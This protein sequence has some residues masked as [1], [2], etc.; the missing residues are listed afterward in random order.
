MSA[1][2]RRCV[3]LSLAFLMLLSG[4][5]TPSVSTP[6]TVRVLGSWTGEELATFRAVIAPF[7]KKS[8]VKIEY[9]STRDLRGVLQRELASGSPPDIAGLD[10]PGHMR[11]LAGVG[12]LHDLSDT[13]EIG[14]Y[15]SAVAPT[16]IDLGTVDGRLVG[17]FVRSSV[18]GLIWYQPSLFELGTPTTWDELQRMA[19]QMA[20]RA[21]AEWCVG[22]ASQESS[23][24]PGTDWI[25]QFLLRGSG[26]RAYDAWV[27]GTLPWSSPEVR[28]AFLAYGQVVAEGAVFG[29][30]AGAVRTDFRDAGG[31]LFT[32]PPGCLFMSQGSFMASFFDEAGKKS[33]ADYDFFPFP[34][35]SDTY[36]GSVIGGGD[37]FGLLTDNP[38]AAALI[39]YLVSDEAQTLW[40]SR[41]GGSLSVKA[42]VTDYPDSV[43]ERAARLLTSA[44]VFRFDGSDLMPRA[45]TAAFYTAVL[46]FTE[47]QSELDSILAGLDAV[48]ITAYSG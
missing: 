29:G 37:L 24:W 11:E 19:S 41:G 7:E 26:P 14:K 28:R 8:G 30:K 44:K 2:F 47:D 5:G 33:H 20:S 1:A 3:L 13:V 21:S 46:Q 27:A 31:P 25:E 6:A 12:A 23:G 22:L 40:V 17:V 36:A 35:L 42:T 16:F 43:T 15:R 39:R 4:C 9:A 38:A 34:E 10:G 32:D 18:K 48:R 45:M